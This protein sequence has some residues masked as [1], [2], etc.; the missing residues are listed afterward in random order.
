MEATLLG[1]LMALGGVL[2][3]GALTFLTENTRRKWAVSDRRYERRKD[4]TDNRCQQ[5][6]AYAME[7]TADFRRLMHDAQAYLIL[8]DPQDA[9]RRQQARREWKDHIDTKLFALG[10]SIYALADQELKADWDLLMKALDGLYQT[11]G[12][13]CE[14]ALERKH[15]GLNVTVTLESLDEA[16]LDFSKHLGDFYKRIDVIRLS[17]PQE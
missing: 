3:G 4:I 13:I 9:A 16:W 14:Y 6:Q 8:H 5:A 2:L 10:P 11:Y 15:K 17:V 1:G 7:V 12:T